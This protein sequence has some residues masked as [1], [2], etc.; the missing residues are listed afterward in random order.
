[1]ANHVGGN[2]RGR[3]SHHSRRARNAA[4]KVMSAT[5]ALL[6]AWHCRE[7]G[8]AVPEAI[9]IGDLE[10]SWDRVWSGSCGGGCA[11]DTND[12]GID[13]SVVWYAPGFTVCGSDTLF[14]SSQGVHVRHRVAAADCSTVE[15]HAYT[16]GHLDLLQDGMVAMAVDSSSYTAMGGGLP[17]DTVNPYHSVLNGSVVTYKLE[18]DTLKVQHS[19][20]VPCTLYLNGHPAD[21]FFIGEWVPY[22]VRM[23]APQ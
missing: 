22:W 20:A 10:G 12:L 4:V 23:P 15:L 19:D 2:A 13:T 8:D 17:A 18:N 21:T 11:L 7:S 3:C 6:V 1:M 16:K 5:F 9:S 14:I